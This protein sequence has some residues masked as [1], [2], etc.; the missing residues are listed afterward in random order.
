MDE[1]ENYEAHLKDL[2]REYVIQFRNLAYLQD[3]LDNV[4]KLELQRS[5]EAEQTMRLAVEKMR[6]ENEQVPPY[7][8]NDT[9]FKI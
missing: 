6:Q 5:Y 3:Q 2:Y 4:E 8:L 7:D 9:V 1:Y